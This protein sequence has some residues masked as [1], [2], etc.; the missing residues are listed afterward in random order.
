MKRSK[1]ATWI[2]IAFF[3]LCLTFLWAI[4]D[5]PVPAGFPIVIIPDLICAVIVYLRVDTYIAWSRER[6]KGRRLLALRDGLAAGIVTAIIILL[7]PQNRDPEIPL[8]L[9]DTSCSSASWAPSAPSPPAP[10]T[11]SAPSYPNGS[12]AQPPLPVN[13]EW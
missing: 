10:S 13:R 1:I 6:R 4:A 3:V 8:Q 7:I 12:Q 11:P 9:F 2:A 5:H